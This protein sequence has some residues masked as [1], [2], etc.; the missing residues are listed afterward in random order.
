MP[1]RSEQFGGKKGLG[2]LEKP[3]VIAGYDFCPHKKN[4]RPHYYLH[5]TPGLWIRILKDLNPAFPK[6]WDLN[7]ARCYFFL[8]HL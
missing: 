6:K 7:S 4:N 3:L 2:P 8:Y 5:K 1:R